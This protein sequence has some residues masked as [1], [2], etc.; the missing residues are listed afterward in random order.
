MKND[1]DT[2][3]ARLLNIRI[4]ARGPARAGRIS[5]FVFLISSVCILNGCQVT[6]GPT[7]KPSTV[8]ERQDSALHDPFG[9]TTDKDPADISGGNIN[10]Y[11]RSAM[12]K[13]LDHVLNP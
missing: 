10:Q 2:I 5:C 3:S 1:K 4:S 7:T 11:D 9:Y 13:D 12:K 8:S 6:D